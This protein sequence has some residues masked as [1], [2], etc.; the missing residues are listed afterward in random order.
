[1]PFIL[2]TKKINCFLV[3]QLFLFQSILENFILPAK[4]LNRNAGDVE[5]TF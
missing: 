2:K 1:M 4:A 5:R 3:K